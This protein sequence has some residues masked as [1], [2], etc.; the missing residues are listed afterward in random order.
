MKSVGDIQVLDR[1][2]TFYTLPC[3][4]KID[5]GYITTKWIITISS[6]YPKPL[7]VNYGKISAKVREGFITLTFPYKKGEAFY[8]GDKHTKYKGRKFSIEE[9]D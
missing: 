3:G 1:F 7:Y 8:W 5:K 6:N 4:I 9:G 2:Y